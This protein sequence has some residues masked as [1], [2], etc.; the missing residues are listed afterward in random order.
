MV[1]FLPQTTNRASDS[2]RRCSIT[3]E[4]STEAAVLFKNRVYSAFQRNSYVARIV[5]P[6]ESAVVVILPDHA[7][8]ESRLHWRERVVERAEQLRFQGLSIGLLG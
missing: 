1:L 3:V 7:R 4:W 8:L 6:D 5:W 2:R